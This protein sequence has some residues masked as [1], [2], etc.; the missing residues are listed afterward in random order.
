MLPLEQKKLFFFKK[1]YSKK[2][3]WCGLACHNT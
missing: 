3:L 2:P 1:N